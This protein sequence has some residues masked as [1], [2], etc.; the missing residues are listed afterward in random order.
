MWTTIVVVSLYFFFDNVIAYFFG[1]R[2]P[3]FGDSIFRNQLWVVLHMTGGSLTL[4]L[5]PVQFWGFVRRRWTGFHRMMGKFYVF[6]AGIAGL[7]ALRLSVVSPCVPCRISLFILS[8]L[9]ILATV[10]AWITIKRGLVDEHRKFM[11]RSYI[12]V[13]AFVAVRIDDLVSLSFLFSA[14][15]DPLFRRVVNEY[16]FSFVPLIVGEIFMTWIPS[17]RRG[18]SL[19]V[20]D[21]I[22][23][24]ET[25]KTNSTLP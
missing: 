18:R 22:K 16:I 3:I 4:L 20:R 10:M 12:C 7:S 23:K 6:G 25:L 15:D 9:V 11:V 13:M 2:S 24:E 14:I 5:G 8:I 21:L 19:P 1:Y 17:W